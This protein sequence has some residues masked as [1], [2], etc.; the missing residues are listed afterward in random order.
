ML[1]PLKACTHSTV[2][3]PNRGQVVFLSTFTWRFIKGNVADITGK[4]RNLVINFDLVYCL[5]L[6]KINISTMCLNGVL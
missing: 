5:I 1:T 4:F 3:P 2:E 6:F